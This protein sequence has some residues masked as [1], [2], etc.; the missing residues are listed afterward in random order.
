MGSQIQHDPDERN[1]G[2]ILGDKPSTSSWREMLLA[3]LPF[4][5]ILLGEGLP[6]LLVESRL[7]TWENP[8]MRILSTSLAILLVIALLV[9]FVLALRQRW[10]LWSATW[11]LFFCIPLL[12][13][14]VGLSSFL[15]QGLLDFTI[16]QDVVIYVWVPL[17]IAV[18]LY[19]VT[20][21]DPLRGL[22]A[23]L[24]VVYLLWQ[25][26]MESVPDA[27]ELA[28]KA[29]STA[30]VCLTIAFIL[31]QYD[32][33]LGL[34]AILVMNLAVGALFAYAGIYHGGTLPFIAA[35][36]NLV[37][38]A[39]SL[40]P[41]YLATCSILIGPL[42]AW[43]FRQAGHTAGR[44]GKI[45]YHLALGGLLLVI[46]ANLQGL[47][48][49]L[50]VDSPSSVSSA[51]APLVVL[52]MAVYSVGVIWLYRVAP[53]PRSASAW[54]ERVLLALLP[55]GIPLILMLTFITWRW[56]VSTIYGISLLW[57]LPHA[58]SL[59]V[60]VLWL[61]LSVWVVAREGASSS[62][63]ANVPAASQTPVPG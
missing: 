39:R 25:P 51:M 2:L 40:I 26:N 60:G 12:L 16:T 20:R 3:I 45:A 18:L 43:K 56:P 14:A 21:L 27:I 6:M 48:L 37:E 11:M 17:G 22:L 36:P 49:T 30:L 46:L 62:R 4:L 5:L 35:G 24:P 55:L 34:Y 44:A 33:R 28:I 1:A 53:F 59:S 41:Q 10:P 57:E 29:L 32:W 61:G 54:G 42:F 13:L 9:V 58:L 50:Q 63:L 23:A 52:G 31:R 8:T 7:L 47:V 38:V 19:A 15:K